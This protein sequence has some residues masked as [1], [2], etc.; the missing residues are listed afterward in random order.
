M[1]ACSAL[2]KQYRQRLRSA[3]D[4]YFVFLSGPQAVIAKRIQARQGHYMPGSLLKSQFDDLE[5]PTSEPGV[6]EIDI[7]QTKSKVLAQA[8]EKVRELISS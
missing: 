2:K 7:D 1:V 8:L 3:G 5:D 6:V 4:V